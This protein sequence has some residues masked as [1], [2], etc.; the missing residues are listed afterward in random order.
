[1]GILA[2]SLAIGS[3]ESGSEAYFSDVET[4]VS[5]TIAGASEPI[6]IAGVSGDGRWNSPTWLVTMYASE[7]KATTITFANSSREDITISLTVSPPSHDNGNLSSGFDNPTPVIPGKG[8]ASVVFW[9]ETSQSVAPGTYSSVITV[10]H[11]AI[12]GSS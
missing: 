1:M 12:W 5:N 2:L 8:R 3:I 10:E 11:Q 9:V 7:R 6:S 4:T